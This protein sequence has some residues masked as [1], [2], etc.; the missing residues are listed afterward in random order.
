MSKI[1]AEEIIAIIKER[2]D[3]FELNPDKVIF[4]DYTKFNKE[5]KNKYL[6]NKEEKMYLDFDIDYEDLKIVHMNENK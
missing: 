1:M 6:K 4:H 2:E 3:N 5:K